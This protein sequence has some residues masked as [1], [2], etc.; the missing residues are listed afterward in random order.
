MK[1]DILLFTTLLILTFANVCAVNKSKSVVSNGKEGRIKEKEAAEYL[2]WLVPYLG[3][4]R[5]VARPVLSSRE[6]AARSA[7]IITTFCRLE[8]YKDRGKYT[9]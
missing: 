8:L 6:K 5:E 7:T 1:K 4:R 9:Y 2:K 3:T